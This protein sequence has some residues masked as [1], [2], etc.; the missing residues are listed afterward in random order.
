M[1]SSGLSVTNVAFYL[2]IPGGIKPFKIDLPG[3]VSGYWKDK[4]IRLFNVIVAYQKIP[5]KKP[6][7]TF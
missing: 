2:R 6:F 5:F 7:T 4:H 3:F 1:V